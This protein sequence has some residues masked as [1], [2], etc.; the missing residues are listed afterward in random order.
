MINLW[1]AIDILNRFSNTKR[2]QHFSHFLLNFLSS[3]DSYTR[4]FDWNLWWNDMP[5]NI[6]SMVFDKVKQHI[7]WISRHDDLKLLLQNRFINRI[8]QI[9][10]IWKIFESNEE[11]NTLILVLINVVDYLLIVFIKELNRILMFL[12]LHVNVQMQKQRINNSV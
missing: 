4:C 6:V 5:H 9:L 12:E 1:L 8:S 11:I 7:Q 10:L 2:I 3:I